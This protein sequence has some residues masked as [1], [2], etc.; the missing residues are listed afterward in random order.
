MDYDLKK[1]FG[2]FCQ[3][4]RVSNKSTR[5][6]K[7]KLIQKNSAKSYS[8]DYLPALSEWLRKQSTVSYSEQNFLDV[9][10][11]FLS[12]G[13][14]EECSR[15]LLRLHQLV[16]INSNFALK[17]FKNRRAAFN[18]Y[19]LFIQ[20]QYIDK[21][22]KCSYIIGTITI[23]NLTTILKDL[24]SRIVYYYVKN[25]DILNNGL[26]LSVNK[27][28]KY[29]L[30]K[31]FDNRL[32]SQ[33]RLSGN[34]TWLS[35]DLIKAI[36]PN[37]FKKYTDT[38]NSNTIVYYKDAS[39]NI[40]HVKCEDIWCLVLERSSINPSNYLIYVST[41]D[42]KT[43]RV[44]SPTAISGVKKDLSVSGID[45]I[46]I[47]HVMPID[48]SLR[49]LTDLGKIPTLCELSKYLQ[50]AKNALISKMRTGISDRAIAKEAKN[51]MKIVGHCIDDK[52]LANE[53]N[54]VLL[55]SWYRLMDSYENGKK[56]NNLE[57]YEFRT[58]GNS[59]IGL[60]MPVINSVGVKYLVYRDFKRK[61]NC[62]EDESIL[63]KSY[64]NVVDLTGYLSKDGK[65]L[66]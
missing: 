36:S 60:I 9:V 43:Y 50:S 11:F 13:M 62:V 37:I 35:L 53:M 66:L 52:K 38:I 41:K 6:R 42:Y 31:I 18:K 21:R 27:K 28:S 32:G 40:C 51:Q 45:K 17:T 2:T 23:A 49:D 1:E 54:L 25:S 16:T 8:D 33:N 64:P 47:D 30:W 3:K 65:D 26:K 57:F 10:P 58:D 7:H 24:D 22:R 39:G 46:A 48:Q 20:T 59:F 63:L 56:S 19:C 4:T 15:L 29:N 44:L 61:K 34:K 14:F 55:D 5:G 12:R